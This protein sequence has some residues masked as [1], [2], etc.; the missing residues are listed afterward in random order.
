[1]PKQTEKLSL[2]K[3]VLT[4]DKFKL[5]PKYREQ[6]AKAMT[7]AGWGDQILNLEEEHVAVG[8]DEHGPGGR[9]RIQT[10]HAPFFFYQNEVTPMYMTEEERY[11]RLTDAGWE[12]LGSGKWR[13]K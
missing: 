1:M 8:M 6:Y 13:R 11:Y 12:Q 4:G 9:A 3:H 5:L 7:D 2:P 10:K